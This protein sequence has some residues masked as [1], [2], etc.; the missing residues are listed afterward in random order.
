MTGK[1]MAIRWKVLF[2]CAVVRRKEEPHGIYTEVYIPCGFFV[3]RI[4]KHGGGR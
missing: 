3:I 1:R 4:F 2:G